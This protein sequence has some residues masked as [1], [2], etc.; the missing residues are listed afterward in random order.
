MVLIDNDIILIN[1]GCCI[2]YTASGYPIKIA[3]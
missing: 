2:N 1:H 3:K